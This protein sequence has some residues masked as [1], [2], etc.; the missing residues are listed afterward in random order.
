MPDLSR[1]TAYRSVVAISAAGG[2]DTNN[3]NRAEIVTEALIRSRAAVAEYLRDLGLGDPD[4]IAQESLRIVD[5]A[6]FE[7]TSSE[8]INPAALCERAIRLTVRQLEKLLRLV[9]RQSGSGEEPERLG[10]VVAARLP[11]LLDQFPEA[12][13][14]DKLPEELA[15]SLQDRLSPVVPPAKPRSMGRQ[16]LVLVPRVVKR[17]FQSVREFLFKEEPS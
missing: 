16:G 10:S 5:Q 7:T 15:S 13:G 9:A 1:V 8:E 17:L 3:R 4:V 2:A 14:K 12:I 11:V 6:L